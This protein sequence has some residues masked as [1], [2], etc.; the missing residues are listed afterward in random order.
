[1]CLVGATCTHICLGKVQESIPECN[2]AGVGP[3]DD[4]QSVSPYPA[5]TGLGQFLGRLLTDC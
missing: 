5:R 4:E 3:L 2:N 1:M